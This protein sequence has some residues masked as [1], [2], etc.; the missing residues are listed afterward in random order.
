MITKQQYQILNACADDWEV[1]YLPF[2]MVNFGGQVFRRSDGPSYAQYD[3]ER[4]WSVTVTAA[5]IVS[6]IVAII[7]AGLL[8]CQRVTDSGTRE[9]LVGEH[10]GEFSVY[11][12]YNCLTF[13]DHVERYGYGPHEFKVTERGV[14]EIQDDRYRAYVQE[15]G[16]Q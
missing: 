16:W 3:D 1:F 11:R 2:A 4:T 9:V 15:L 8:T 10:D 6:D 13:D 7:R 5:D 12:G 14:A